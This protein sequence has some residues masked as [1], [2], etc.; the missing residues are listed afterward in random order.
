MFIRMLKLPVEIRERYDLSSQRFVVHA[1][2]PLP[3]E[4]K[5]RMM[6]WWGPILHEYCAAPRGAELVYCKPQ[7]WACP[8]GHR[9]TAHPRGAG[10]S[11]TTIG[12]EPHSV[13]SGWF[14]FSDA[15]EFE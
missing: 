3:A 2:A 6:D 10:T 1:A 9:G 8:P 5:Q 7:E 11:A 13:R 14:Y 15:P 4:V 12:N